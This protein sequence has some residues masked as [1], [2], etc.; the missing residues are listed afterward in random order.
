MDLTKNGSTKGP[1]DRRAHPLFRCMEKNLDAAPAPAVACRPHRPEAT[2]RCAPVPARSDARWIEMVVSLDD[3]RVVVP[4]SR[5]EAIDAFGDGV[6]VVVGGATILQP[7]ITAG[8]V[9]P[10]RALFLHRAG[11]DEL[12]HDGDRVRVGATTTL[13]TIAASG[14]EPLARAAGHIGD[15]EIRRQATL[16]GNVSAVGE[17]DLQAVLLALEASVRTV[18]PSGERTEGVDAFLRRF[19][20]DEE[21]LLLEAEFTVPE[22]A[23]Y[24]VMDRFHTIPYTPLAVTAVRSD[25]VTRVAAKGA[26]PQS[27]RLPSVET[28]LSAGASPEEAA[29]EAV[30]DADP[31]DDALASAWYRRRR[32]PQLVTQALT[33]L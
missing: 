28:A 24:A 1:T 20:G 11:L 32:L 18:G 22:A 17:G 30:A 10:G 13:E 16:G 3:A 23:G 14:V 31:Y 5:Q 12:R 7:E 25:G 21:R 19:G 4:A 26:A 8:R 33:E 6:D 15:P 27:G 2:T 9:R 29:A